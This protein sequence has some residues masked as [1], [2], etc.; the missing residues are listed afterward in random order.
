V[1]STRYSPSCAPRAIAL[2]ATGRVGAGPA[3][4][5]WFATAILMHERTPD[6]FLMRAL[7]TETRGWSVENRP[8]ED[9]S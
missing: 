5:R 6:A 2:W 7:R 1:Q 3:P 8:Q 4:T 9:I